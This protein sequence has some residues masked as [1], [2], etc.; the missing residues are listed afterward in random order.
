MTVVPV[1]VEALKK[2]DKLE[3][4]A[5][6]KT[7]EGWIYP[8]MQ[9]TLEANVHPKKPHVATMDE[10]KEVGKLVKCWEAS[11]EIKLGDVT[12]IMWNYGSIHTYQVRPQG[13]KLSSAYKYEMPTF[14]HAQLSLAWNFLCY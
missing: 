1:N 6:W 10:L 11:W 2:Q 13:Y 8:G 3:S 4:E 9:T 5:H 7:E 12:E 14:F